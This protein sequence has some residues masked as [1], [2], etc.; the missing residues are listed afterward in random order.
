MLSLACLR[1]SSATEDAVSI[2]LLAVLSVL[3]SARIVQTPHTRDVAR[4][5]VIAY[6]GHS[7][8]LAYQLCERPISLLHLFFIVWPEPR[9]PPSKICILLSCRVLSQCRIERCCWALRTREASQSVMHRTAASPNRQ[10]QCDMHLDTP[11]YS[12]VRTR[13]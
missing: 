5:L 13:C 1:A 6:L 11:S 2:I 12:D 10:W 3:D 4:L 9:E 7:V 8:S